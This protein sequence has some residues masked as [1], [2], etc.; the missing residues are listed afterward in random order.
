VGSLA[1][2]ELTLQQFTKVMDI[3]QS[4]VNTEALMNGIEEGDEDDED[5]ENESPKAS[6]F[7]TSKKS[8]VLSVDNDDGD[9]AVEDA[10]DEDSAMEEI[11]EEEAA[12]EIF[13][14]LRK[15]SS[16]LP[17]VNFLKWE[18]VQEL[19]DVEAISKDDLAKSIENVGLKTDTDAMTFEQFFDLIQIIDNFVDKEKLPLDQSDVVFEKRVQV[20][21]EEDV[22]RVMDLVDDL[23]EDETDEESFSDGNG[24]VKISYVKNGVKTEGL[25]ALN[26][27]QDDLDVAE[28]DQA[29]DDEEVMEMFK[30]LSKGKSYITEKALRK[31][32]EL[33]EIIE[34]ELAT[35][36]IIDGYI[37]RI[38]IKE[39]QVSFNQFKKFIN[40]LD[41]VLVDE[42]GEI[43]GLDDEGKAV[44]LEGIDEIDDDE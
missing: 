25:R 34:A 35:K 39:G 43:L 12:R 40:L 24:S 29:D 38:G 37:S 6:G 20:E 36:E 42:D 16:R 41:T 26:A 33:K 2:N 27:M 14:K 31:W 9:I 1:T 8:Q 21:N 3:I 23:M 5:D 4:S 15:G 18:D 44:D 10:W 11:S 28:N 22:D 19:L 17:I 30:E 7:S 32:D 13:D